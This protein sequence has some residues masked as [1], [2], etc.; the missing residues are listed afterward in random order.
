MAKRH[1]RMRSNIF[2]HTKTPSVIIRGN[3]TA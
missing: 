3:I 2:M 1:N